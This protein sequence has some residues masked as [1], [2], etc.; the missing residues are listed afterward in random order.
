V[1]GV[2]PLRPEAG[3]GPSAGTRPR[4]RLALAEALRTRDTIAVSALR[5]ALGAIG[6]AEAVEPGAAAAAGSAGPHV[7]GAVSGLGAS[8]V[9]RRSLSEAQIEQIVQAEATER[10]DAARDY[11]RAGQAG[12]ADLLRREA[13]LLL[14]VLADDDRPGR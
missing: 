8:E 14:A 11:E 6:N 4:L 12:R 9:P 10:E 7:A 5:S 2:D 3:A 13:Q 1:A